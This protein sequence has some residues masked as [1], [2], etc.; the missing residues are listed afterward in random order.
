[1]LDNNKLN[2]CSLPLEQRHK[3]EQLVPSSIHKHDSHKN[4]LDGQRYKIR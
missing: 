3:T 1:M 2:R 4:S